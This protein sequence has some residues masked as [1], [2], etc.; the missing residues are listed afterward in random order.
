MCA[1]KFPLQ[2]Y[3]ARQS[4]LSWPKIRRQ[5]AK[6]NTLATLCTQ[7]MLSM[8]ADGSLLLSAHFLALRAVGPRISAAAAA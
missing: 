4:S 5:G 6:K 8:A 1:A 3:L 2:V 7:M